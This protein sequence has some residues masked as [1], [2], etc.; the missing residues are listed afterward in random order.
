VSETDF[1]EYETA[2][3]ITCPACGA[4]LSDM[5]AGGPAWHTYENVTMQGYLSVEKSPAG[6]LLMKQYD[7]ST[8]DGFGD[9]ELACSCGKL[10]PPSDELDRFFAA[11]TY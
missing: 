7:S 4:K 10:Q 2:V 8:G 5:E 9:P 11:L 6:E 3:D 1:I